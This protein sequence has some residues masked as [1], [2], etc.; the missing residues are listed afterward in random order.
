MTGVV[1]TYCHSHEV[2]HNFL[3]SILEMDKSQLVSRVAVMTG[4][5]ALPFARNQS[6]LGF[7]E[8]DGEWL[9]ILDSDMGFDPDLVPRMLGAAHDIDRPIVGG[10]CFAQT[11]HE[12][13]GMGGYVWKP[14][15]TLMR[16]NGDSMTTLYEYE[17]DA[18]VK[19]DA[20]GAACL[21]V[22]RSVAEAMRAK[23][24]D[25]W[26]DQMLTDRGLI[27]EDVSFCLRAG[28]LGFPI[29][30]HTGIKTNHLKHTWMSEEAR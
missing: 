15:P 19:V 7:L 28:E 9:L 13:D 18:L 23:W 8:T 21:L 6:M 27:G 3:H 25:T 5:N 4:T 22:H 30:V 24:G 16:R 1:L 2:G 29:H 20:T 10:L 12:P 17:P 26:F 11:G 14:K